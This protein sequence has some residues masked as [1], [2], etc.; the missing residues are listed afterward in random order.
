[1]APLGRRTSGATGGLLDGLPVI[2][3]GS[4]DMIHSIAKDQSKFLGQLSVTRSRAASVVLSNNTLWV[5]GGQDQ[6]GNRLKTTEFVT[7]DG[8][9]SQGPDLP[10]PL[11]GHSI[12]PLN[13]GAFIL[14][15]GYSNGYSST[16][17]MRRRRAVQIVVDEP[18]LYRTSNEPN[19]TLP[20]LKR[21]EL[22]MTEPRTNSEHQNIW[23][24]VVI[25]SS[26]ISR[27]EYFAKKKLNLALMLAKNVYLTHLRGAKGAE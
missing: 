17:S 20:N 6:S 15:G 21:T 10:L 12:V 14:I 22:C 16:I 1:M 23:Y 2:C 13:S 4:N 5:T 24:Y 26:S 9:T 18:R 27:G 19:L 11:Y 7:K 25:S 3:G 8:Q